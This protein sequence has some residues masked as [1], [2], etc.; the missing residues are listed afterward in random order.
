MHGFY[1]HPLQKKL[2]QSLRQLIQAGLWIGLIVAGCI[3]LFRLVAYS[4][5]VLLLFAGISAI[6][7]LVKEAL[8]KAWMRRQIRH[9]HLKI[10]VVLAGTDADIDAVW[11]QLPEISRN[12]MKVVGRIDL[13]QHPAERLAKLF[14]ERNVERVVLAAEHMRF[15]LVEEAVRACET[16]GVEAW[17][18]TEFLRTEH[19]K[20]RFDVLG[21]LPMLVFRM[22]PEDYWS[23]LAK[24][25]L[26]R[27]VAAF[28]LVCTSPLWLIAYIGIKKSSP[29]PVM[30]QQERGGRYGKPFRMFKFRTMCL[31]AD[32]EIHAAN[33]RPKTSRMAPPLRW[34]ETAGLSVGVFLRKTS[35]DELPQLFNILRGEMSLVGPRPL[36]VYEVE[37]IEKSAQRRRL[38]V[39]PGLTCLWQISGRSQITEFDEWVELDLKYIDNWSLWMDLRILWKTIPVVM[40]GSGA[41]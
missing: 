30:F 11:N 25:V 7:L 15:H 35:I 38:S 8:L 28:L 36:P 24:D 21:G 31:D 12:Q 9:G 4:R 1:N 29:G 34:K 33:W 27:V 19:A 5:A 22:T 17:L 2:S 18:S 23:L 20:P 39:K 32:S 14:R 41:Q 13:S 6:V 3:I 26:D 37:K 40:R 10:R 16:E